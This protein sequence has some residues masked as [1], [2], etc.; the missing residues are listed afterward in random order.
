MEWLFSI[1]P[2]CRRGHNAEEIQRR[3]SARSQYPP[4]HAAVDL[5]Q[6]RLKLRL[7]RGQHVG[8]GQRLEGQR[9]R[10][11]VRLRHHLNAPVQH[12]WFHH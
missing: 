12:D 3:S 1:T 10:V 6:K 9:V 4:Y 11:E 7:R 5:R 8:D 2:S